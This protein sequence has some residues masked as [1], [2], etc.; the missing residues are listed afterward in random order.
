MA[1][2]KQPLELAKLKGADR[3]DPQRYPPTVPKNTSKLGAP[4]RHLKPKA[5]AAWL[6]LEKMALPG[7]L[8]A[9]ERII[10]EIGA[11]LLSEYREEPADFRPGKYTHLIG[12]LARLGMTPT[13][14]QKLG[15]EDDGKKKGA[16]DE[17]RKR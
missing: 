12:I 11:N 16:F 6:E 2:H 4:P 3:K 5:R 7:V 10:I 17:F 15:V 13:D 1:R 9:A 14:R 8:T